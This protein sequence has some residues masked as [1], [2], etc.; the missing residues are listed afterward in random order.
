MDGDH[1]HT[2]EKLIP[3]AIPGVSKLRWIHQLDYATSGVLIVALNKKAA[4][5]ASAHFQNRTMNK[6]YLALV[7]GHIPYPTKTEV[8]KP[9]HFVTIG[10]FTKETTDYGHHYTIDAPIVENPN[11]DF[12]MMIGNVEHPGKASKT[13][14]TI[15]KHGSYNKQPVTKIK[16]KLVTGRRHQLRVH[17]MTMGYPIVGDA[18][19]CN[20]LKSFRMMLHAWILEIPIETEP[21]SITSNDPFEELLDEE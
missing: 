7:F 18:T 11:D 14:I 16:M 1:E 10:S 13:E 20:D 17:L 5:N 8:L 3:I 19:Y 21:I 15:L 2:I 4:A 6:Y 9:N 12:K